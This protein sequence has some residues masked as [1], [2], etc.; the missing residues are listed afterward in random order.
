MDVM[1]PIPQEEPQEVAAE[2]LILESATVPAESADTEL[3][4]ILEALVYVTDEPLTAEQIA[5][6]LGQP[7][8]KVEG[9]LEQLA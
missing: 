7:R 6:A 8:A 3:L 5:S 2:Q 4:A 1:E 9:L